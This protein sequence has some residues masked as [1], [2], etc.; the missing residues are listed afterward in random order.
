MVL[1]C[2]SALLTPSSLP[3][4]GQRGGT[5]QAGCA[6]L[7]A[8]S[9]AWLVVSALLWIGKPLLLRPKAVQIARLI[10]SRV[11]GLHN[12]LTNSVLLA[13]AGD[14]RD[15]PFLPA[16]FGEVLNSTPP[17]APRRC[18]ARW[19]AEAAC[20][21]DRRG[22]GGGRLIVI[23]LPATMAH[24][25]KQLFS[26]GALLFRM[27]ARRNARCSPGDVTLVAGQPLEITIRAEDTSGE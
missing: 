8:A 25:W 26:P 4:D 16:I 11:G 10:E 19:R 5:G 20:T 23:L 3:G 2:G 6:A 24:G 21:P 9:I 13:R 18:R 22:V 1:W 15:S 12:G 17:A 27:S 7:L 14:L